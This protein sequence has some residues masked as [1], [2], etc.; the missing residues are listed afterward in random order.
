MLLSDISSNDLGFRANDEYFG[1][2]MLGKS[3]EL[4]SMFAKAKCEVARAI[5]L[6]CW[7]CLLIP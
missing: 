1:C 7:P 5:T 6:P 3:K 4:I 2:V